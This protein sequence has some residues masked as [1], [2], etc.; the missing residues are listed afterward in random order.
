MALTC[1][2]RRISEKRAKKFEFYMQW[3]ICLDNRTQERPA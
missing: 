1:D 3:I 2:H